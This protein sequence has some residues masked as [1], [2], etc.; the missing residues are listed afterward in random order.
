MQVGL[1]IPP[2]LSKTGIGRPLPHRESAPQMSPFARRV[3]KGEKFAEYT[4][5]KRALEKGANRYLPLI[6]WE[7]H[8][9]SEGIVIPRH[10]RIALRQEMKRGEL[11]QTQSR[12]ERKLFKPLQNIILN[13]GKG[14]ILGGKKLGFGKSMSFDDADRIAMLKAVQEKHD[15]LIGRQGKDRPPV[16]L[17]MPAGIRPQAALEEIEG[18]ERKY[19]K[20]HVDAL[21]N[22]V[23]KISAE[24]RKIWLRSGLVSAEVIAFLEKSYPHY[25]PYRE[26]EMHEIQEWKEMYDPQVIR[27]GN[28]A[29]KMD[30]FVKS[31]G[32]DSLMGAD[33]GSDMR[34]PMFRSMLGMTK[35]AE[36]SP[37]LMLMGQLNHALD[38]E[39]D[40]KISHAV[41]DL[42]K[43]AEANGIYNIATIVPEEKQTYDRLVRRR[44]EGE[45]PER[46]PRNL[47]TPV[48]NPDF[49]DNPLVYVAAGE[50]GKRIVIEFHPRYA[51]IPLALKS[52][53]MPKGSMV[54]AL[55][56][57]NKFTTFIAAMI[58]RWNPA[59]SIP[60]FVR[61]TGTA[62]A[63]I[64]SEY[65]PAVAAKMFLRPT[66][67]SSIRTL[68]KANK[69]IADGTY[70]PEAPEFADN[71]DMVLFERY[72]AAG[73]P[74]TF[75]DLGKMR[76]LEEWFKEVHQYHN[77]SQVHQLQFWKGKAEQLTG[78]V[79]NLNDAFENTTRFAYFRYGIESGLPS[80]LVEGEDMDDQELGFGAKNLTV[81]FEARGTIGGAFNSLFMFA[82]ANVQSNVRLF[83]A[84]FAR[85]KKGKRSFQPYAK[86]LVGSIVTLHA[87][88][89]FMNAVLG[90]TDPDDDEE[91]WSKIP[92]YE[93]R[94]N[95]ILLNWMGQ[96]GKGLK[97]PLP[98]GYNFFAAIGNVLGELYAGTKTKDDA[99]PYMFET[100]LQA[101][102]PVGGGTDITD[103]VTPTVA[104]PF[105]EVRNNRDWKGSSIYKERYGDDTIP[106][107]ELAFDSVDEDVQAFTTWLN[108]A[109]GGNKMRSGEFLGL[110]LSINPAT[111]EHLAQ[112]LGGGIGKELFRA[113]RITEQALK[114]EEVAIADVPLIRRFGLAPTKYAAASLY[115][116][117][118]D[119]IVQVERMYKAGIDLSDED[120]RLGSL[121]AIK[122]SAESSIKKL[123]QRRRLYERDSEEYKQ[124]EERER[125]IQNAFNKRWN[126]VMRATV[127]S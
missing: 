120:R 119:K 37:L 34:Q 92:D 125:S 45:P 18:F 32:S 11:S 70:D 67:L 59:F 121:S 96:D 60:N 42:I 50:D 16:V 56:F 63:H 126:Q 19:G 29:E 77:P 82:N 41:I 66:L 23:M 99:M 4:R 74:V 72:R 43:L 7:R 35:E 98:Y 8:L 2:Q 36:D 114:G 118:R 33:R 123:R 95:L 46:D 27:P 106:D 83:N 89:A 94:S 80:K 10:M 104:K 100:A 90:G 78:W 17:A 85:D 38:K 73:A 127:S 54:D 49:A 110:D 103:M 124:L 87:A 20:E 116:E 51:Q 93:K 52:V 101:F 26:E 47:V 57:V 25:V 102:S 15:A 30:T 79:E 58:T 113:K 12:I 3:L 81:N 55:Q 53:N 21:E 39:L 107:S 108:E 122:R 88:L 75:L 14:V 111:I 71:P 76:G 84:I 6:E 117:R 65:G 68:Y 86:G 69:A 109:A 115:R 105:F 28:V 5:W 1:Y 44:E 31:L 13:R 48:I 40:S 64:T 22:A 24:T 91:Y 61:D 9:E 112:F 97:V 62:S